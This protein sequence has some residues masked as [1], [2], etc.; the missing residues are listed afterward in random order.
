MNQTPIRRKA[1]KILTGL[2]GLALLVGCS[3]APATSAPAAI[4][5]TTQEKPSESTPGLQV[6]LHVLPTHASSTPVPSEASATPTLGGKVDVTL[7]QPNSANW[8]EWVGG[9]NLPVDMA[10]LPNAPGVAY[11]LEQ[12]GKIA[13]VDNGKLLAQP[14]LDLTGTAFSCRAMNR[15]CWASPSIRSFP[16]IVIFT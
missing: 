3:L 13:I 2:L 10:F 4:A 11:I 9:L 15:V 8:T 5:T 1:G 14:L 12:E 7:P 6:T 16:R